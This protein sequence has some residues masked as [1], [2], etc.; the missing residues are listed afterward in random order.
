MSNVIDLASRRARPVPANLCHPAGVTLPLER[1]CDAALVAPAVRWAVTTGAYAADLVRLLPEAVR[2]GDR[3]LVIGAGIGVVSTLVA[4][5][6]GVER[7]LAVEPN[8]ALTGYLGRVHA[9]NGVPWVETLNGVPA[10]GEPGRVPFFLRDD[11]RASSP[12][13]EDGAWRQVS[14]VPQVDLD[15]ILAEEG[16][17][18]IVAEFPAACARDLAE[19]DLGTVERIALAPWTG[20]PDAGAA[21][22]VDGL[23]ALFTPKGF[24]AAPAGSA[25]ILD[26]EGGA[27]RRPRP[28]LPR[29]ASTG[30]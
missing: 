10:V 5:C 22:G 23:A 3:V 6:P 11:L 2:A 16:V 20:D 27:C 9:L 8:A 4:Q 18:L 26:R 24:A 1:P 12:R 7:V 29:L 17:S 28:G 19:A 15:L 13:P 21:E 14:L 25:L 30:T